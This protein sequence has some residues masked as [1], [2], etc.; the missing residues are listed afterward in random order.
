MSGVLKFDTPIPPALPGGRAGGLFALRGG[1]VD[2]GRAEAALYQSE[3]GSGHGDSTTRVAL[4]VVRRVD[5]VARR[6]D[7]QDRLAVVGRGRTAEAVA[8]RDN[9]GLA[10]LG[11]ARLLEI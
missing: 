7:D 9:H 3:G 4:A 1:G 2:R 6:Y 11:R 10:G 8:A 5:L